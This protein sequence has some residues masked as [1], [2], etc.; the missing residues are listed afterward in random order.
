MKYN[1]GDW[2]AIPLTGGLYGIGI[3]ARM[4]RGRG[5]K[6]IFGYFFDVLF[7]GPPTKEDAYA[8]NFLL[9]DSVYCCRFGD[10]GLHEGTWKVVGPSKKWRREDWPMPSFIRRDI[11][12][13]SLCQK[14]TYSDDD[15]HKHILEE[16]FNCESIE[17]LPRDGLNGAGAV[18]KV[19]T[20]LLIEKSAD[21]GGALTRADRYSG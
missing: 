17:N 20:K 4:K 16:P 13:K 19:L 2:I 5:A 8:L 12:N 3:I 7:D 15:P 18:E 14:I 21:L 1:E 11:I 6:A 10:L 9:T